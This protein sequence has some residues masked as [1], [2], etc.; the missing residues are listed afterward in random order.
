M[1]Q[2]ARPQDDR[3]RRAAATAPAGNRGAAS[4]A[5]GRATPGRSARTRRRGLGGRRQGRRRRSPAREPGAARG[6][7]GAPDLGR[8]ADGRPAARGRPPDACPGGARG[9]AG[10][11]RRA[12][13]A[14]AA[15]AHQRPHLALHPFARGATR[16]ASWSRAKA[17]GR[18]WHC[19]RPAAA[20]SWH[21][22]IWP[23]A[24][25]AT[26]CSH[27]PSCGSTTRPARPDGSPAAAGSGARWRRPGRSMARSCWPRC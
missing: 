26:P 9:R 20:A 15:R 11:A 5:P 23:H 14:A 18:S 2:P 19:P 12:P 27:V 3:E 8:A 10:R 4:A 6:A 25:A 16:P 13:G 17:G 24:T 22:P 21:S 1:A 7:A